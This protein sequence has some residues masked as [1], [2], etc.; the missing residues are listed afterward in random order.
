[1]VI[2]KETSVV[3]WSNLTKQSVSVDDGRSISQEEYDAMPSFER[4]L[5]LRFFASQGEE[6]KRF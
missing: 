6:P 3:Y 1:M 5:I 2:F 4:F